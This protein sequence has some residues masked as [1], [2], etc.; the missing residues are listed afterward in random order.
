MLNQRVNIQYSIDIEELPTEVQRLLAKARK[1]NSELDE[2]SFKSLSDISQ[3]RTLSLKTLEEIDVVRKKIAAVDYVLN[4][5]CSIINGF[6]DFKL[7][8]AQPPEEQQQSTP[9]VPLPQIEV[10]PEDSVDPQLYERFND[11]QKQ[12]NKFQERTSAKPE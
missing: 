1:L 12:L 5:A 7:R 8:E 9:S 3:G 11:I 2:K 4:D 6:L 10:P